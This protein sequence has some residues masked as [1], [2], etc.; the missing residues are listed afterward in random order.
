MIHLVDDY[1]IQVTDKC[2]IS[3][4]CKSR[5]RKSGKQ[6]LAFIHPHYHHDMVHAVAGACEAAKKDKLSNMTCELK[7]AVIALKQTQTQ[8]EDVL[9]KTLGEAGK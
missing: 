7:E 3:G 6:D 8:F 2:Y 1:Y 9:M 5:T 4:R